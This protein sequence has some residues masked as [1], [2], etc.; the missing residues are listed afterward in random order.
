MVVKP[1]EGRTDLVSPI[2]TKLSFLRDATKLLGRQRSS[3]ADR[4]TNDGQHERTR[5]WESGRGRAGE[6]ERAT[7]L[8]EKQM[9]RC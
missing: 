3:S 6:G 9:K 2:L 7:T 5:P 1:W 8:D 4:S